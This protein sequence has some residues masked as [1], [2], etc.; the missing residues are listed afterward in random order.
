MRRGIGTLPAAVAL[1]ML[2]ALVVY[3]SP[4]GTDPHHSTSSCEYF[5]KT[6]TTTQ[7]LTVTQTKTNY[8]G[9]GSVFSDVTITLT[10]DTAPFNR[11]TGSCSTIAGYVSWNVG[12]I[13]PTT[14]WYVAQYPD[15]TASGN[16]SLTLG[17]A[18]TQYSTDPPAPN[19]AQYT[20]AP[21]ST[22]VCGL[23]SSINTVSIYASDPTNTFSVRVMLSVSQ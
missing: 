21:F 15:G 14:V 11:V 9:P 18:Y 6:S 1:L 23:Q 22:E 7:T 16:V 2:T 20:A 13:P 4:T 12:P 5:C 3:S 19:N 8:A 17:A 10:S